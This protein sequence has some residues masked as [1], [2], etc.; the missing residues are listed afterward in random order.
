MTALAAFA[1]SA[2]LA[3]ERVWLNHLGPRQKQSG[4]SKQR[5]AGSRKDENAKRR[6]RGF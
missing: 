1:M 4:P 3:D 6:R 5:P 2:A